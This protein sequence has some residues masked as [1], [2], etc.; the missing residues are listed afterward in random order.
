M[1]TAAEYRAMADEC[2]AWAREARTK[3]VRASYLQLAQ[4]WLNAASEPDGSP[5][6]PTPDKPTETTC[7]ACDGSFR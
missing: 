6:K 5:P 1:K 7:S 3:E 4:V 2:F